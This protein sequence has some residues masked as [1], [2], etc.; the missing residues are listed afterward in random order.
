MGYRGWL[1]TYGI[2]YSQREREVG[3]MFQGDKNAKELF[4]KYNVSYVV[5]TPSAKRDFKANEK[6][7]DINY[8]KIYQSQ[9]IKIYKVQ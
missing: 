3:I 9:N 4:K 5:I 8:L 6:I 7:F 2:N 1:W